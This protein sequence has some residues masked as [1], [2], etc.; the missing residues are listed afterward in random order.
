MDGWIGHRRAVRVEDV[1]RT[2]H[3]ARQLGDLVPIP[4]PAVDHL[5]YRYQHVYGQVS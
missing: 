1:A 4:E 2:V 5:F 3:V